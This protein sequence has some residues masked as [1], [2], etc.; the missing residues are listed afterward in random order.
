MHQG[1][2]SHNN[3]SPDGCPASYRCA[4][5]AV[6]V[7]RLSLCLKRA[8][9]VM[10]PGRCNAG[11]W[12]RYD[13]SSMAV[14]QIRRDTCLTHRRRSTATTFADSAGTSDQP[15]VRSLSGAWGEDLRWRQQEGAVGFTLTS[16]KVL[17]H[18]LLFQLNAHNMLNAWIY[19][20]LHSTC[21]GVRYTI[22]TD[23]NALP[24]PKQQILQC[25]Y[26][27]CAV[28]CKIYPVL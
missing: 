3:K 13:C 1:R 27:G 11:H 25:Y 20:Y 12:L 8:L 6:P 28:K 2:K 21:F 15:G 16:T 19:Y 7:V 5:S 17:N 14:R 9:H 22:D 26:I 23:T 18:A 4:V 10:C 24:A